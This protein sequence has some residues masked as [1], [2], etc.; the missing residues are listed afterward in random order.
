MKTGEI[1]NGERSIILSCGK[2]ILKGSK[3]KLLFGHG[4]IMRGKGSTHG[5]AHTTEK[6]EKEV[7]ETERI[8]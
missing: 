5:K 7:R 3:R 8:D 2:K 4:K 6:S 1:G